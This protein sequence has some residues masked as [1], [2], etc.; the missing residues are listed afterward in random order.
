[1]KLYEEGSANIWSDP[2]IRKQLLAAH[3][4]P[5]SDAASRKPET[6]NTTG[7]F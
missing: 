5:N 2:Y 3:I 4:N 6:I 7:V 1:M